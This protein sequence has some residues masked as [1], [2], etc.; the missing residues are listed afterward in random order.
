MF[1]VKG[2]AQGTEQE[3][4]VLVVGGGRADVD[5][6]AGDHFGGVTI[7]RLEGGTC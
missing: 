5:D 1:A 7:A 4:G 6:D 2:Y 3:A